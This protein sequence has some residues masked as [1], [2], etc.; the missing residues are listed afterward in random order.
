MVNNGMRKC[1]IISYMITL[2]LVTPIGITIGIV[3]TSSS[4]EQTLVVGVMQGLAGGTLLYVTFFEVLE[5]EK[6]EKVGMT[7]LVG[8]FLLIMGFSA[9]A[10]LEAFG[11]Q[12]TSPV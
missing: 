5:R 7:G 2:G 10:G 1:Q 4:S 8:A 3:L 11:K 6:L 12:L 9:M